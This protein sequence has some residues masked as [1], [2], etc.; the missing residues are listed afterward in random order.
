MRILIVDDEPLAVERL[1]GC[2]A[3]IEDVEVAAVATDGAQALDLARGLQPDLLLL[4]I[5]MP[6]VSGLQVARELAASPVEVVFVTALADCATEAFGLE[7]A[8]YLLKP[9]A[10]D[11]L[12]EAVN[13]ARRRRSAHALGQ[14]V[15]ALEEQIA[16][17]HA[18]APSEP[19][20]R[21]F[22]IRQTDGQVRVPV[23][24][25]QRIEAD[26]DYALLHTDLRTFILRI[27]MSELEARLDPRDL[28]RVHRSGFVRP[29]A[30]K[31]VVGHRRTKLRLHLRDGAVVDVG[32][33][34]G[35]RVLEA[36]GVPSTEAD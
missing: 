33:S 17:L 13:R 22:W 14:R 28:L 5:Q 12:L 25:I 27:T 21:E 31:K 32:K 29:E 10:R 36:L 1:Q 4:D 15:N 6:G 34:Y 26:R 8:D 16:R 24:E 35:G 11:R 23:A 30:V 19:Y 2:L 9:V 7:A 3:L 20:V 18:R